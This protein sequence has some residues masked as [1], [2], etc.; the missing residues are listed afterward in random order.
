MRIDCQSHIFP[1]EYVEILLKANGYS[2]NNED[3]HDK[4]DF[5]RPTTK[6]SM[7]AFIEYHIVDGS[8]FKSIWEIMTHQSK[9]TCDG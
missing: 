3:K 7:T 6:K 9:L 1:P 2:D 8:L 5:A 4:V